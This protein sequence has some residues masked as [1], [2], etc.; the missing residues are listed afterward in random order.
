MQILRKHITQLTGPF[1]IL[2]VYLFV[3]AGILFRP[4]LLERH[5]HTVVVHHSGY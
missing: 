4:I 2:Y 1:F 5:P 3:F